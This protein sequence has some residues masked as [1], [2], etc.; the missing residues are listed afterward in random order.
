MLLTWLVKLARMYWWAAFARAAWLSRPLKVKIC[1]I[2]SDAGAL[3]H[4][5]W[6]RVMVSAGSVAVRRS[7]VSGSIK[8]SKTTTGSFWRAS[9][10]TA[11][12]QIVSDRPVTDF[13][14]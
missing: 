7:K 14:E 2:A 11:S 10:D 3:S 5:L 4:G 8:K 9:F 13:V 6:T 1:S 12:L